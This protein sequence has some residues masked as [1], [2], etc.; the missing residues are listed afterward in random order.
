[1][2]ELLP[3][4]PEGVEFLTKRIPE[5]KNLPHALLAFDMG[6]GKTDIACAAALKVKAKTVL[7]T[8]PLGVLSHW[9]NRLIAWGVC[10]PDDIYTVETGKSKI[11][12]S[13][14]VILI[15]HDKLIIPAIVDQLTVREYDVLV[16]DEI[17]CFKSM[18]SKRTSVLFRGNKKQNRPALAE[19]CFWK[20]GLSG[21]PTP[22]DL[23]ELYPASK[24]LAGHLLGDHNT[25]EKFGKHY[26]YRFVRNGIPIFFGSRKA[27]ELKE[28][29]KP[30]MLTRKAEDVFKDM[31]GFEIEPIYIKIP[32]SELGGDEKDTHLATLRKIVGEAKVEPATDLISLQ[33][34]QYGKVLVYTYSRSVTEALHKALEKK[35]AVKYY[36][37]M[38]LKEKESAKKRF[39]ED[40]SCTILIAQ[41]NAIGTGT[42][43]LQ[44]VCN[45]IFYVEWDWTAGG[46]KQQI[47]RLRRYLQTKTVFVTALIAEGTL[48][49]KIIRSRKRKMTTLE[50]IMH[51]EGENMSTGLLEKMAKDIEDIKA[52]LS[53]NGKPESPKDSV[54]GA[55]KETTAPSTQAKEA[56]KPE[57]ASGVKSDTEEISNE[58]CRD[59]AT[60]LVNSFGDDAEAKKAGRKVL[61]EILGKFGVQKTSELKG[62]KIAQCHAAL[63]AAVE[64]QKEAE[65][66]SGEAEGDDY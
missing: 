55:A 61:A 58:S 59:A 48:D 3:W 25:Y 12:K 34:D 2:P 60:E 56:T 45:R 51:Y 53:K 64:A 9:R 39:I 50:T 65:Q 40:K 41:Q 33:A 44:L 36:G 49:E 8:C 26:S 37:G 62:K 14:R 16:I 66:E 21:T 35:G 46:F 43:G 38:S 28:R 29:L 13:A 11:P 30:F 10:K 27:K 18:S 4:Q 31:P 63:V 17:Q 15:N 32:F 54:K 42:D 1:M 19:R 52:L 47:A 6:L 5:M 23:M 7:I 20:W 24:T 22:N 57:P